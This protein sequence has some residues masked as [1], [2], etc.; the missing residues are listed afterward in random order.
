[1][2]E[3]V[4]VYIVCMNRNTH[5]ETRQRGRHIYNLCS[6]YV[7]L[8]IVEDLKINPAWIIKKKLEQQKS[9][10]PCSFFLYTSL[11][12]TELYM[13]R[14]SAWVHTVYTKTHGV[15]RYFVSLDW[16]RVAKEMMPVVL[17]RVFLSVRL[18]AT[19]CLQASF[20]CV[21]QISEM[22]RCYNHQS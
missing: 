14:K 21:S 22:L 10:A 6:F 1:M 11:T 3:G 16:D 5:C 4:L 15:G 7:R 2:A 19:A 8:V 18:C 17:N 9:L 12:Y 20:S 13:W